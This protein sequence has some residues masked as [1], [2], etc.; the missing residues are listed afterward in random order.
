[1]ILSLS[2]VAVITAPVV[3]QRRPVPGNTKTLDVQADK[4]QAEYLKSLAELA[5]D[6]EEAGHVDKARAMLEAILAIKPDVEAIKRKLK[7]FDEEVF[8]TNTIIVDI[9]ASRP[10]T[11]SG[12]SVT[13]GKPVRI[14]AIGTYKFIVNETVGPDGFKDDNA[15]KDLA[16]GISVGAL[17]G[18]V[19]KS[20][21]AA[22]GRKE[23]PKPFQLGSKIEY[24]PTDSGVLFLKLNT[25]P[26]AKC[27]G[28]VKVKI[29]GN[30]SRAR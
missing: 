13:K 19:A 22:R 16:A 14:E 26:T 27:I 23:G 10:W 3:A 21:T 6:Y 4:A 28:K 9:D 15:T 29:S 7:E 18:L 25:P 12:L 11:S 17:M 8:E 20:P 1:M 5:T 30:I 24:K 2:L